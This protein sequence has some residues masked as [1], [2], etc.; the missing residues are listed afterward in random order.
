M[1]QMSEI[2]IHLEEIE[3]LIKLCNTLD[4]EYEKSEIGLLAYFTGMNDYF[5]KMKET[6]EKIYDLGGNDEVIEEV[7]AKF[8]ENEEI[9]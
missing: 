8:L 2:S 5:K 6:V 4:E 9:E 1:N 7:A 3:S